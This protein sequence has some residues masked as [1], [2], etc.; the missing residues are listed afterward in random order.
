[1][2]GV[3]EEEGEGRRGLGRRAGGD[4]RGRGG[5]GRRVGGGLFFVDSLFSCA[6]RPSPL[7]TTNFV[8]TIRIDSQVARQSCDLKSA[9]SG[10]TVQMPNGRRPPSPRSPTAEWAKRTAHASPLIATTSARTDY[11]TIAVCVECFAGGAHLLCSASKIMASPV[12]STL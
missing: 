2:R 1:M 11:H 7:V 3:G 8:S 12:L 5:V 10:S 9:L 6:M 4:G